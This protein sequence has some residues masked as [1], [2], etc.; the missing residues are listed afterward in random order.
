LSRHP[1]TSIIDALG[2]QRL[3]Y[4]RGN[5]VDDFRYREQPL[6]D[7]VHSSPLVVGPPSYYYPDDWASGPES[8]YSA[9]R[10]ANKDRRRVVYVGANDGMLHA[11]DAGSFDTTTFEWSAGTGQ[12]MFAYV[13]N[14]VFKHLPD[15]TD[16]HYRH[17]YY[18]DA[19]PRAGDAFINGTWRTVLASGLRGGGQG[20]FALD[21]TYPDTISEANAD[22]LPLWEYSDEDDP[23]MGYSF[24]SPLIVRMHNN[25]WAAVFGNGY[26]STQGDDNISSSGQSA[27]YIV[28]LETGAL[29][30]K[31]LTGAGSV[32][33]PNGMSEPTAVDLDFDNIIDYI[34]AGDLHGNVWGFDVSNSNTS[35]WSLVGN[36]ARFTAQ[37]ASS[38]RTPITTPIAVGSH[39][40]SAGVM[41]FWGTGKYLEKAD[42]Q[43]SGNVNRVYGLWDQYPLQTA[44]FA[45]TD[46]LEQ[47]ITG[48]S[49]I[50]LDTDNNGVVDT[51]FE[52]RQGSQH[53]V[54]WNTHKGWFLDLQYG[55]YTGEQ[56]VASPILRE[57]RVIFNTHV[58]R[59]NVCES[60]ETGWLLAL[61]ATSGAM[62]TNSP[63][64]LDGDGQ[65]AESPLISVKGIGSPISTPTIAAAHYEDVII[66]S[67]GDGS[68]VSTTVMDAKFRDGRLT[69]RELK[70]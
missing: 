48:E 70:P 1:N 66:S 33:D 4:I 51:T 11:F 35:S 5:A 26:N 60:G 53:A 44:T 19:T 69:W 36:A 37:D 12:E 25:R 18:V 57:G 41:L 6:G 32:T 45:A 65:F 39:P 54:D 47:S 24:A 49:T 46:L 55:A 31:F 34:Y 10:V 27:L 50:D 43:P 56:V 40:N 23:D 7:I 52:T 3:H 15:L 59:G 62:P 63:F 28:D 14:Q 16:K 17:Q 21:I 2:E 67:Q 29:I 42:V 64:D 61:D 20:V 13:P 8:G 22:L 58:P 30:K 9:Y 38:N 68:D